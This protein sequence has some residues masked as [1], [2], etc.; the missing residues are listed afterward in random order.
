MGRDTRKGTHPLAISRSVDPIDL[1]TLGGV[2]NSLQNGGLPR[3]C[4]SNDEDPELDIVGNLR[5][6]L[7]RS[8][9]IKGL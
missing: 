5:E 9:R 1:W 7:L 3:I 6:I 4:P 8:H 2:T